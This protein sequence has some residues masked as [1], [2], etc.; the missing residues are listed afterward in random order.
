MTTRTPTRI[1]TLTPKR[2]GGR[3]SRST[4]WWSPGSA[5]RGADDRTVSVDT[6]PGRSVSSRG[7]TFNQRAERARRTVGR[8]RRSS[9]RPSG[10]AVT[11][12]ELRPALETSTCVVPRASRS[13]RDGV[14]ESDTTGGAPPAP[15]GAGVSRATARSAAI[16]GR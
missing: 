11:R 3:V 9:A 16:T 8:P 12:I 2:A 4:A 6:A 7:V 5:V 13:T 15:A 1:R 10:A 14:A